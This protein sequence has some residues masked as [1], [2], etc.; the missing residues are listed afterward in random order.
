M[1]IEVPSGIDDG[2]RISVTVVKGVRD[3]PL[4]SV[5]W[6][7]RC[8]AETLMEAMRIRT[9][10]IG[11]VAIYSG[12]YVDHITRLGMRCFVRG[13]H[14]DAANICILVGTGHIRVG[15]NLE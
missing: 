5:I 11:C 4:G 9:A 10:P 3:G 1:L 13:T 8:Q 2:T 12:L 6:L 7:G 15:A 14:A